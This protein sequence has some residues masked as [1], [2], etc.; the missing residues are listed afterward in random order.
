MQKAGREGGDAGGASKFVIKAG[1]EEE[2]LTPAAG[3]FELDSGDVFYLESAGGGG[4]GDPKA[5]APERLKY[6]IE[7]GYVTAGAAKERYGA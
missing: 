4:Y 1:T 7:Q 5:R 2:T 3:K 6:D